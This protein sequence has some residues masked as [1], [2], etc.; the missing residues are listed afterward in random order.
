M[1][2]INDSAYLPKFIHQIFFVVKPSRCINDQK[3]R[4]AGFGSLYRVKH[5]GRGITAHALA[6]HRHLGPLRPDLQLLIRCRAEGIRR[7]QHD[8]PPHLLKAQSQLSHRGCFA[9][10]VYADHKHHHGPLKRRTAYLHFIDDDLLEHFP[11]LFGV[12]DLLFGYLKLKRVYNTLRR[13]DAGIG[14]DQDISQFIIK[15]LVNDLGM[16]NQFINPGGEVSPGL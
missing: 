2:L 9:Y 3:I 13:R 7:C 8:R 15:F 10:A 4:L 14:Q 12:F 1:L 11:C 16:F 6:D 5:Y